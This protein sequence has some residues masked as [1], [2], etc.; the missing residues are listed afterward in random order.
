MDPSDD[1][2]LSV[3]CP[4]CNKKALVAFMILNSRVEGTAL[5]IYAKCV[6]CWEMYKDNRSILGAI[7]LDSKAFAIARAMGLLDLGDIMDELGVENE[8]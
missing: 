1:T 3:T 7:R 4:V 5:L 6:Y 2:K 8:G